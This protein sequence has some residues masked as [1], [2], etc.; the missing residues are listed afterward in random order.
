M[1]GEG[2]NEPT[3]KSE[4]R[5]VLKGNTGRQVWQHLRTWK[6]N[7][8]ENLQNPAL[9]TLNCTEKNSAC[10]DLLKFRVLVWMPPVWISSC[11]SLLQ[12]TVVNGVPESERQEHSKWKKEIPQ[13]RHP[14]QV[15]RDMPIGTFQNSGWGS[16]ENCYQD[17]QE[18]ATPY[19]HQAWIPPWHNDNKRFVSAWLN[20]LWKTCRKAVQHCSV[21]YPRFPWRSRPHNSNQNEAFQIAIPPRQVNCS[22][23]WQVLTA[24]SFHEISVHSTCNRFS[25][26]VP[27]AIAQ[28]GIKSVTAAPAKIAE[29]SLTLETLLETKENINQASSKRT[30]SPLSKAVRYLGWGC[31]FEFILAATIRIKCSVKLTGHVAVA[32]CW[33]LQFLLRSDYRNSAVQ[34]CLPLLPTFIETAELGCFVALSVQRTRRM[35]KR[36]VRAMHLT[37]SHSTTRQVSRLHN[38]TIGHHACENAD[39]CN[40]QQL[41]GL[42]SVCTRKRDPITRVKHMHGMHAICPSPAFVCICTMSTASSGRNVGPNVRYAPTSPAWLSSK[43]PSCLCL[44]CCWLH[45]DLWKSIRCGVQEWIKVWSIQFRLVC[46]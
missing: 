20:F 31:C 28:Q 13:P 15:A 10:Y 42:H 37:A 26:I 45:M 8:T 16:Q 2:L 44:I 17:D 34:P 29:S 33:E 1:C 9:S 23:R 24:N 5:L 30:H 4:S 38:H 35:P 18:R 22:C 25:W 40:E 46:Q 21:W 12:T 3:L 27:K 7:K 6:Q 32:V 11:P 43:S 41:T 36:L 39:L 19:V 14:D